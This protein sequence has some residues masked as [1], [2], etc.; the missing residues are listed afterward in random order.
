VPYAE[1]EALVGTAVSTDDYEQ[2]IPRSSRMWKVM[3]EY[4][5][6][7]DHARNTLAEHGG[8]PNA[9][10]FLIITQLQ[11]DLVGVTLRITWDDVNNPGRRLS[12]EL[13]VP[14]HRNA[15]P[16]GGGE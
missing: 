2:V 6:L 3:R 8:L 4:E 10:A 12:N 5:R 7:V 11:P 13:L 1:L 14:V 15:Y 9:E 16:K